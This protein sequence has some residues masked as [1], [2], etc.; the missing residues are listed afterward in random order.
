[1][2]ILIWL[3]RKCIREIGVFAIYFL[4]LFHGNV[5]FGFDF[6]SIS[7]VSLRLDSKLGMTLD[8]D[9][10]IISWESQV[11]DA[12]FYSNGVSP[13]LIVTPALQDYPSV[14]FDGVSTSLRSD[15]TISIASIVVLTRFNSQ[16]VFPNYNG[17]LTSVGASFPVIVSGDA[18]Q[19]TLYRSNGSF[20][21]DDISVNDYGVSWGDFSTYKTIVG[22]KDEVV[23]FQ[24]LLIGS[25]RNNS[26]RY[27]NG[28]L[29]ELIAFD[30]ELTE[31]EVS[32]VVSYLN[33]KHKSSFNIP[34]SIQVNGFCDTT[35]SFEDSLIS[36]QWMDENGVVIS[37]SFHVEIPESGVYSF[38]GVGFLG[39]DVTDTFEVIYPVVA[40]PD[41]SLICADS[42]F[43]W[44][45]FLDSDLELA[46]KVNGFFVHNNEVFDQVVNE[47]D[48]VYLEVKGS[49]CSF[50]SDTVI[51]QIDSFA[52]TELN[53]VEDSVCAGQSILVDVDEELA[54]LW[55]DGTSNSSIV[56]WDSGDRMVELTDTNGCKN[57]IS[58]F[59]AVDGIAPTV[60]FEIEQLCTDKMIRLTNRS[61]FFDQDGDELD[62]EF[63]S[64]EW[65]V[66]GS[67]YQDEN[68]IEHE[69]SM[70]LG[71]SASLSVTSEAGCENTLVRD[72]DIDSLK[73][74]N[75]EIE[76]TCASYPIQMLDKQDYYPY[77][78]L[79]RRWLM[80]SDT[81]HDDTLKY[82]TSNLESSIEYEVNL[83]N[84][85]S[86]RDSRTVYLDDKII[87]EGVSNLNGISLHLDPSYGM[88]FS[89]DS[90][91]VSWKS[92]VGE[93]IF[94][95][96][97]NAP[98]LIYNHRLNGYPSVSFDGSGQS[99]ITDS[100]IEI[101]S[102]VVLTNFD[103]DSF[104]GY[105]GLMSSLGG[106]S[107]VLISG[108]GNG[109]TQ[110]YS[111]A[112][113]KFGSNLS[114][115][116]G[117]L[118]WGDF[119]SYKMVVG[120]SNSSSSYDDLLL[121]S[122]RN[123]SGRYWNGEV[124][125][126][127]CFDHELSQSEIDTIRH[128]FDKKY[129]STF[130]LPDTVTALSF[131]DYE[132]RFTDS[133]LSYSWTNDNNEVIG[134]RSSLIPLESTFYYFKGVDYLENVIYDTVYAS[135]LSYR[136]PSDSF[137]CYDSIFEWKPDIT[138]E[139]A[140]SW[141]NGGNFVS[142]DS[143]LFVES[144]NGDYS[145]YF[146][147]LEESG[148]L[149]VS[150]TLTVS[151]DSFGVEG[152][153]SGADTILCRGNFL[154]VPSVDLNSY[155]WN[156]SVYNSDYLVSKNDLVI[157]KA[158][159]SNGCVNE[160]SIEVMIKGEVPNVL[161]ELSDFACTNEELKV[162]VVQL[163]TSTISDFEWLIDGGS[164][165]GVQNEG[166]FYFDSVGEY[167]IQ[168]EATNLSDCSF[169]L[170]TI[171][172]VTE[173]PTADFE[174]NLACSNDYSAF[175]DRSFVQSDIIE[176]WEW[177]SGLNVYQNQNPEIP[178]TQ[179]G[180]SIRLV[181][182]T[183]NN[184]FDTLSTTQNIKLAP[185]AGFNIDEKCVSL[186]SGFKDVSA[187]GDGDITSYSWSIENAQLGGGDVS[188]TFDDPGVYAVQLIVNDDNNC[189]DTVINIVV[190]D[191][192]PVITV[193]T[194]GLCLGGEGSLF[195]D[196]SLKDDSIVSATWY[197]SS[198]VF[199]GDTAVFVVDNEVE[200]L[201]QVVTQKECVLATPIDLGVEESPHANFSVSPTFGAS[202]LEIDLQNLSTSYEFVQWRFDV[203]SVS[204]EEME[205]YTYTDDGDYDLEL[206]V[207]NE[208]G[209]SDV[210]RTLI[211]VREPSF[212]L[213]IDQ[214]VRNS[215]GN[216]VATISNQG[217][218]SLNTFDLEFDF[219]SKTKVSLSLGDTLSPG[220]SL[221]YI[222]D[223]ELSD[224]DLS[225]LTYLCLRVSNEINDLSV[226]KCILNDDELRVLGVKNN[227]GASSAFVELYSPSSEE[228]SIT[229][230]NEGGVIIAEETVLLE[231]GVNSFEL[232]R[233]YFDEGLFVVSF[234]T[235]ESSIVEKIVLFK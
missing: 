98:K 27:W 161:W 89:S 156:D 72:F 110:L 100:T 121:G 224:N 10:T 159:N 81:I 221:T 147:F 207:F 42:S 134:E 33:T 71:N 43:K 109:S 212:D 216:L 217:T 118:I 77:T 14:F 37:N 170:D 209:C 183:A 223:F 213:T 31:E 125:E 174:Y 60:D 105:N 182:G 199:E 56:I 54:F 17:L 226:S 85:C 107:P 40:Y 84:G 32:E 148:C 142:D 75:F 218:V 133:L 115:N 8:S 168:Y 181:V 48:S 154:T 135:L 70:L 176:T 146:S 9:S 206:T 119:S 2:R 173:K 20:F 57:S 1:M 219:G 140:Y 79:N 65:V 23:D 76:Y 235:D 187:K 50:Y 165:F 87:C 68:S 28:E 102:I 64:I 29:V 152:L 3:G 185:K 193:E 45:P 26:G 104:S 80:D 4:I 131:C 18:G 164:I 124:L 122:D 66:N 34:N 58:S 92:R 7:G 112:G 24:N 197:L 225:N 36:Y 157:L 21:G 78:V 137:V 202:P 229:V 138:I 120:V 141:Y 99:L 106:T 6:P 158:T 12:V 222:S 194:D 166:R 230:F 175:F 13:K 192:L 171:L 86:Y 103:D 139:G 25:D 201:L 149:L 191:S 167:S 198:G 69:S 61:N 63:S 90:T 47:G 95:R 196:T 231:V 160:D 172:N 177:T 108:N 44:N 73:L 46:W 188:Y 169:I 145:F 49:E 150:D 94:Y 123:N 41:K 53:F 143:S 116:S 59:F 11:G 82:V 220:E 204:L 114:V 97:L 16:T 93:A 74:P 162:S 19:N 130:N 101:G 30:H 200:G 132:I 96:N 208:Y 215:E 117:E 210:I 190:I 38:H 214:F 163:D 111:G 227:P 178:L 129:G 155:S 203:D 234:K 39:K 67:V 205:S 127:I 179:G 128:Y 51:I 55:D 144:F 153:F 233:L 189:S 186:S 83:S 88:E 126:L 136:Y 180:N 184:C 151:V 15:S 211:E 22:N 62:E 113:S 5:V 195:F 228:M 52:Y 91:I 232:N 35:I